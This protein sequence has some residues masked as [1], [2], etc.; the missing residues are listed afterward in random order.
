MPSFEVFFDGDCPLCM[1]EIAMARRLDRRGRVR[2][3]DIAAEGFDAE[4]L[5]TTHEALMASIHGRTADGTWVTGVEVFRRM[6]AALGFGPLVAVS[7]VPPVSWALEA[8][9]RWFAANRLRLTGRCTAETC[10]PARPG[11]AT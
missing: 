9:Y 3:T 1:R 8:G 11:A 5:G 10:A 7:R 6:Y 4:A 2:F